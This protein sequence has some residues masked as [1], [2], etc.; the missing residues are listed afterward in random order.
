VLPT[1]VVWHREADV[2]RVPGNR[3]PTGQLE[4]TDPVRRLAVALRSRRPNVSHLE[5]RVVL[6]S[7]VTRWTTVVVGAVFGA[8]DDPLDPAWV[9]ATLA[10]ISYASAQTLHPVDLSSPFGTRTRAL[11]LLELVGTVLAVAA[12]GGLLSPFVLTPTTSLLLIGYVWG[13][14]AALGATIAGASAAASAVMIQRFDPASGRS[15]PQ[16]G[17]V[18][19]LSG[20]LGVFARNLVMEIEADRA[21]AM[22]HAAEM[23]TANELLVSL[24]ALAQTLPSSLDLGEV[25]SSI[26]H[27]IHS[28][29]EV[30]ALV[31]F[32]RDDASDGW[33]VELAEGLRVPALIGTDQLPAPLVKVAAGGPPV[34]VSDRLVT[35]EEG[36]SP[37]TRS[38][39]YSAMRARGRLVGLVAIEH[40]PPRAYGTES[41][42][43]LERLSGVFGLSVDN[44]RWFGRLRVFG[45]EAERARIARE[46]H[47]R[48]AQSLAYVA[49]ELERVQGAP[50]D[51]REALL[52]L[53]GVVRDIV[54]ELRETLY[55]LR[56]TVTEDT[57]LAVVA[58]EYV[59]RF[60]ARTGITVDW[61][62]DVDVPLP[63]HCE[64]EIWRVLQEALTNVER[65]SGARHARVRWTVDNGTAQLV[66]EDDGC[67]F[68]P[69]TV[70][71]DHYGLVG[72]RERADA[73][74][75]RLRV[76]S[77][78]GRGSRV[79]L[80]VE[81]TAPQLLARTQQS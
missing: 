12:T 52:D 24:H 8:L 46:L 59:Q 45:A 72:M 58:G 19:L 10:L 31:V 36:M 62:A 16:L 64:Q 17:I 43:L 22:D 33:R 80:Q 47:D 49:F 13:R 26:R 20:A 27:R 65:H 81:T 6:L 28:L 30:T 25:M 76:E 37:V 7:I 18:F 23:A 69:D 5:H 50:G 51:Q 60:E 48:I 3:G 38:G 15:A 2:P 41:V 70:V 78:P 55:E 56:A 74:G 29:F 61:H 44:A 34:V 67:G 32:L 42:A 71:G 77:S 68:A 11:V 79:E 53:H 75:A 35:Q 63:Y 57:D 1:I 66:I 54:S 73:I 39:I 9:L 40:L 21:A 14:H 4:P